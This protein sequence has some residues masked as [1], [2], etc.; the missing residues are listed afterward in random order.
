MQDASSLSIHNSAAATSR[1]ISRATYRS[2]CST[3]LHFIVRYEHVEGRGGGRMH[4]AVH[5]SSAQ[6]AFVRRTDDERHND[7]WLSLSVSLVP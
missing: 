1:V 6:P 2:E 7:V 3:E 5:P 4:A